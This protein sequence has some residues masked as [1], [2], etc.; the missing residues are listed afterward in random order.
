MTTEQLRGTDLFSVAVK[1]HNLGIYEIVELAYPE[2]YKPWEFPYVRKG[3]WEN[4]ENIKE[5]I[6]WL[7]EERLHMDLNNTIRI[8]KEDFY[9][10]SL[11]S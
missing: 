4:K 10:N 5:A 2:E 9:N 8:S 3:F 6:K 7:F 1:K 11:G